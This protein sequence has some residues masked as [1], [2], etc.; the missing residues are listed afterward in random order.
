MTSD[1]VPLERGPVL[2][3]TTWLNADSCPPGGAAGRRVPHNVKAETGA[4]PA[5][6]VDDRSSPIRPL[7]PCSRPVAGL[8]SKQ[9]MLSG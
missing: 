8:E 4:S 6:R 2:A 9:P 7:I 1:L 5:G 3:G